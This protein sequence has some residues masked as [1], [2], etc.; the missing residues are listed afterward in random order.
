MSIPFDATGTIVVGTDRSDRAQPAVD[1]AAARAASRG[2]KLV[3]VRV[4][5]E[6]PVPRRNQMYEAMRTGDW[7]AHLE[8]AS[9]HRLKE[10]FERVHANHPDLEVETHIAEGKPSQVLAQL[11]KTAELVVVGARGAGTPAMVRALGGTAD[12]VV[13]HS[14]GPVAVVTDLAEYAPGGPVVVGLDDSDESARSLEVAAEEAAFNGVPLLAVH[15]LELPP[16]PSGGIGWGVTDHAEG[17]LEVGPLLDDL[18]EHFAER[19]R[20]YLDKYPDLDIQNRVVVGRASSVLAEA[21]EGASLVVVGSRG[22]GGFAGLLLGSTSRRVLR[23]AHAPVLVLRRP[24][25]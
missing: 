2:K 13:S 25:D 23:E 4:N 14:H 18:Q 10:L 9:Q 6:V 15:A 24:R 11:S 21:S 5:P 3:I 8:Q 1:W 19:L 16:I 12:D 17:S 22:R 20:P 7:V